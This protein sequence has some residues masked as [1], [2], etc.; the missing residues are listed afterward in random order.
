MSSIVH[1]SCSRSH[2]RRA[3]ASSCLEQCLRYLLGNPCDHDPA[4]RNSPKTS[5]QTSSKTFP[6]PPPYLTF[7]FCRTSVYFCGMKRLLL[8]TIGGFRFFGFSFFVARGVSSR[9][10][11]SLGARSGVASKISKRD[12][13]CSRKLGR[14]S[15]HRM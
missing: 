4:R 15:R 2:L 8:G 14:T 1:N 11:G 9:L 7:T 12:C 6:E 5:R 10:R 13:L 3:L